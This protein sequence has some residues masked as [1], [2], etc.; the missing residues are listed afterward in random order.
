MNKKRIIFLS[1]T[2]VILFTF[3]I[4]L[5]NKNFNKEEITLEKDGIK[6]ALSVDGKKANS[7][8]DK[9][10]YNVKVKC[11]N[12]RGK[13]LYDDWKLSI[14]NIVGNVTCNIKFTSSTKTNLNDYLTNLRGTKQ[15]DGKFAGY[16]Y[17]NDASSYV[18]IAKT[19]YTSTSTSSFSWD[20]T[21]LSWKSTNH[22]DSSTATIS[23]KIST[24]GNYSF[25]YTQI[26]EISADYATLYKNDVE[27]ISLKGKAASTK[28]CT[29]E[30][31]VS[32][33]DVF[34]VV[35]EKDGSVS[36]GDDQVTFSFSQKKSGGSGSYTG[37]IY[38]SNYEGANPNNYIYFN[39][40]LW[41]IV[42]L[43][44][45]STH[46]QSGKNLV[47]IVRSEPIGMYGYDKSGA[48]DWPNASLNQLLNNAYYNAQDGTGATYCTAYSTLTA[49]CNFTK[50]GIKDA[51]RNMIVNATW[52]LGGFVSDDANKSEFFHAERLAAITD[53]DTVRS[54]T[55]TAYIGLLYPSDYGYSV[56]SNSCS[57]DTALASY[58][59]S[60]CV[61]TS[62]LRG[63][64]DVW[65]LTPDLTT[66]NMVYYLEARGVIN[67]TSADR[68]RYIRPA[69]YLDESV[70]VYA[71]DGSIENP[72]IIGM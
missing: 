64:S 10:Y 67:S 15:G 72:Y 46:G 19:L 31:S 35:Y 33:S 36:Y 70:Y 6:Y 38:Y 21:S 56:D 41:R 34:K 43:F 61:G 53:S 45:N 12:A 20:T 59:T 39:D 52:H 50:I 42:G 57:S 8:P 1:L 29:S 3:I 30:F 55:T 32:T 54:S 24:A 58:N 23:F 11:D 51:Y 26:S 7:F 18:A 47:K 13:W 16:L 27:Y 37:S 14:D 71:G 25:C 60:N 63:G 62:W 44:D 5:S 28:T 22:T 69:L 2:I 48:N 66:S 17:R 4:F 65:L 49:N 9:G 68:A 40:E